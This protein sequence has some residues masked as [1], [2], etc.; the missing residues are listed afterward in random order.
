[1]FLRFIFSFPLQSPSASESL[2]RTVPPRSGNTA[3]PRRPARPTPVSSGRLPKTRLIRRASA[4]LV[5]DV[6]DVRELISVPRRFVFAVFGQNRKDACQDSQYKRN[7]RGDVQRRED[8]I[9]EIQARARRRAQDRESRERAAR[10]E[11]PAE[12]GQAGEESVSGNRFRF[13][14]F[15]LHAGIL[16]PDGFPVNRP[17]KRSREKSAWYRK[18]RGRGVEY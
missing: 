1:M 12:R 5:R 10:R 7:R 18:T 13:R 14:F 2:F 11:N 15:G 9:A 17:E 4:R 6:P 8:I 3:D 16:R